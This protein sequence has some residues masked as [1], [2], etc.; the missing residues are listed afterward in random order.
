MSH[1]TEITGIVF[2]DM[3]ALEAAVVQLKA[4]GISCLLEKGVTPRAYY[5]NQDGMGK[6]DYVLRLFDCA[7]DVGFYPRDGGGYVARTDLFNQQVSKILGV[8]VGKGGPEMAA[9]G[10]LNQAYAVE[11]ATRQAIRQGHTVRRSAR[12]DGSIQLIVEV[13]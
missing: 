12:D 7:Y 11:A 5:T 2:S 8:P 1:T 6:A 9:L 3:Q 10:K 4:Q 13:R